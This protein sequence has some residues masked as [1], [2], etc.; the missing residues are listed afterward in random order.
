MNQDL[1]LNVLLF[2]HSSQFH[3]VLPKAVFPA[4][5][6]IG[7]PFHGL[8]CLDVEVTVVLQRF[9]ALL[10]ELKNCVPYYLFVVELAGSLGPGEL[11]RVVFG[12]EVPMAFGP[13]ETERLAVV[14]HKHDAMARVN[15]S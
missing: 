3:T 2:L 4:L 7:N 14:A 11:A 10:F 6:D 13:A 15:W 9:V 12:L 5:L 1:P 8:H